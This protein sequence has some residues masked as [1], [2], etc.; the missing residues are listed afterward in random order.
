MIGIGAF[1]HT[2][3][4]DADIAAAVELGHDYALVAAHVV[5]DAGNGVTGEIL[6]LT[7]EHVLELVDLCDSFGFP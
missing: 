3:G 6:G 5:G 4:I 2:A 7:V 1:L